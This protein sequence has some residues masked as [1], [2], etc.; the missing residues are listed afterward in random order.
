MK[1]TS[2]FYEVVINIRY[3]RIRYASRTRLISIQTIL[4][5][6]NRKDNDKGGSNS[7][8]LFFF[9]VGNRK[10]LKSILLMWNVI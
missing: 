1:I 4:S 7:I 6:Q 2:I 8:F 5:D 10:Y 9:G 3:T